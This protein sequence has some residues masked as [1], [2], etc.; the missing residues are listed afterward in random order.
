MIGLLF[1]LH[2]ILSLCSGIH[3][4]ITL[5]P[6]SWSCVTI[7]T[8]S[9]L[10]PGLLHIESLSSDFPVYWVSLWWFSR[11]LSVCLGISPHIECLSRDFPS[12]FSLSLGIFRQPGSVTG[13]LRV[14]IDRIW[15]FQ[16]LLIL[17]LLNI[18]V[19]FID[20]SLHAAFRHLV[21]SLYFF[22]IIHIYF[23]VFF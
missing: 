13:L 2:F 8:T 23:W 6:F 17:L 11:I 16:V 4:T 12:I 18:T 22:L 19:N 20:T 7:F 15:S 3:A 14:L 5:H 10:I 1:F 9:S 21:A